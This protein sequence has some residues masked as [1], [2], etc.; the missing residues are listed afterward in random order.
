MIPKRH[1]RQMIVPESNE[2]DNHE[3]EKQI[4]QFYHNKMDISQQEN[5]TN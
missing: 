5:V 4:Q 3:E 2:G 1:G